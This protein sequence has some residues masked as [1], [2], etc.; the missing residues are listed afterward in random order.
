MVRVKSVQEAKQYKID[1]SNARRAKSQA[2]EKEM[3]RVIQLDETEA[4]KTALFNSL[5][6]Q[7]RMDFLA[8]KEITTEAKQ[9]YE[10]YRTKGGTLSKT[11]FIYHSKNRWG[12]IPWFRDGRN[13]GMLVPEFVAQSAWGPANELS[14]LGIAWAKVIALKNAGASVA[15]I[16]AAKYTALGLSKVEAKQQAKKRAAAMVSKQ[17]ED[18]YWENLASIHSSTKKAEQEMQDLAKKN[19]DFIKKNN[20]RIAQEIEANK[21]NAAARTQALKIERERLAKIE[22]DRIYNLPENVAKRKAE[23]EALEM[24]KQNQEVYDNMQNM[25]KAEDELKP[26]WEQALDSE[27]NILESDKQFTTLGDKKQVLAPKFRQS[28]KFANESY[29]EVGK[30]S[31]IDG[32]IYQPQLSNENTAVWYDK[33]LNKV[34]ISHRGTSNLEDAKSDVFLA[35]GQEKQNPRFNNA[36]EKTREVHKAFPK[37]IIDTSGH[38]LGGTVTT[39]VAEKLGKQSWMGKMYSYN[40]GT[41]ILG[42]DGIQRIISTDPEIKQILKNKLENIRQKVDGVSLTPSRYGTT[43]T[44]ETTDN[45]LDAH[46]LDSFLEEGEQVMNF[47]DKL[48]LVGGHVVNQA[49]MPASKVAYDNYQ[50]NPDGTLKTDKDNYLIQ[51]PKLTNN[52]FRDHINPNDITDSGDTTDSTTTTTAPIISNESFEEHSKETEEVLVTKSKIQTEVEEHRFSSFKIKNIMNTRNIDELFIKTLDLCKI[53]DEERKIIDYYYFTDGLDIPF[54]INVENNIMYIAFRGNQSIGKLFQQLDSKSAFLYEYFNDILPRTAS[55][56]EFNEGVMK[57]MKQTYYTISDK[58][59]ELQMQVNKIILTGYGLGGLQASLFAYIYNNSTK[60]VHNRPIIDYVVTYGVPKALI[61][62]LMYLQK[63]ND[64]V[65][66]NIR[67]FMSDDTVPYYFS[68]E[69]VHVGFAFNI[70]GKQKDN[71]INFLLNDMFAT[72]KDQIIQ[73]VYNK[74]VEE[75]QEFYSLM[76]SRPYL[77]VMNKCF[78]QCLEKV[79]IRYNTQA[80]EKA[81]KLI[82]DEEYTESYEETVERTRSLGFAD[83]LLENPNDNPCYISSLALICSNS[84]LIY[85]KNHGLD[86]YSE[87]LQDAI[88]KQSAK[89]QFLFDLILT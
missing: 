49:G 63:Y 68:Y 81:S 24:Q 42:K 12:N 46:K 79:I 86:I 14:Q 20:E 69:Y 56:I 71:N 19:A 26:E 74:T 80:L 83:I 76:I 60:E 34:H 50:R 82:Q 17:K 30:R 77:E 64:S 15:K 66:H 45:L 16:D 22:T 41:S 85:S 21:A 6:N 13:V 3:D 67:V 44:Y 5:T 27:P 78:F 32:Y 2:E 51:N 4:S 35:F 43:T 62:N 57:S 29:E 58:I 52:A 84:N 61:N 47:E 48:Q 72:N 1:S 10:Q 31:N 59:F 88:N 87:N 70:E 38:S 55:T 25:Q 54:L 89:S 53:V 18:S 39:H 9:R 75:I 33:E 23:K 73:L 37:A 7:Q 65:P 40:G 36:V 11:K 28:H 8:G